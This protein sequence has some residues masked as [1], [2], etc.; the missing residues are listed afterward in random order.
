MYEALQNE[1]ALIEAIKEQREFTVIGFA[2]GNMF[3][4]YDGFW[5][6]L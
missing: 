2:D 4:Y 5:H 6:T 3:A 1:Q